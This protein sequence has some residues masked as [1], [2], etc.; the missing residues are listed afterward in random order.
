M[1][2]QIEQLKI[3]NLIPLDA[4]NLE[5]VKITKMLLNYSKNRNEN[6]YVTLALLSDKTVL[7]LKY[8]E[9]NDFFYFNKILNK[10]KSKLEFIK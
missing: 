9:E 8:L 3:S 4:N 2:K 7:Q 5:S 10:V 6:F 1:K